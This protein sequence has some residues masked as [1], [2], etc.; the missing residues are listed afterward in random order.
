MNSESSD[1]MLLVFEYFARLRSNKV[2]FVF[3]KSFTLKLF[4]FLKNISFVVW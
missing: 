1:Y 3:F 4:H 2:K